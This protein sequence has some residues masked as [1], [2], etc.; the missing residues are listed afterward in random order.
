MLIARSVRQ[1]FLISFLLALAAMLSGLA[2]SFP[3]YL[4]ASALAAVIAS[5]VYLVATAKYN[6]RS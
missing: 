6:R 3:T 5:A 2:L 1:V 4:P